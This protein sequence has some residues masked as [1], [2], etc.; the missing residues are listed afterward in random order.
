ML[1]GN[2]LLCSWRSLPPVLAAK[3]SSIFF[4]PS[5]QVLLSLL[6]SGLCSPCSLWLLLRGTPV[7]SSPPWPFF[8]LSPVCPRLLYSRGPELDASFQACPYHSWIEGRVHL[9]VLLPLLCLMQP[10]MMLAFLVTRAHGWF[11]F[12][13]CLPEPEALCCRAAFQLGI[14]QLVLILG[15]VSASLPLASEHL[16][17]GMT[18]CHCVPEIIARSW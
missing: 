14:S 9:L 16:S 1:K 12:N 10:R 17:Q 5:F 2:L 4:R 7:L 3:P 11:V 18:I 8:W 13:W 6:V 15:V